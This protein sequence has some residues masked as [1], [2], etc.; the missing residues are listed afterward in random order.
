[1]TRT[2]S[3]AA[4]DEEHVLCGLHARYQEEKERDNITENELGT[5]FLSYEANEQAET[6]G[7]GE[8]FHVR[9]KTG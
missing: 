2:L 3:L 5:F 9:R 8:F 1:M 4:S 7:A 6:G